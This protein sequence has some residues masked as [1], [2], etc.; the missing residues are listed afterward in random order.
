MAN[1]HHS[2]AGRDNERRANAGE[3]SQKSSNIF[4]EQA[5]SSDDI[6]ARRSHATERLR[7]RGI[8][9]GK[10]G[11][12]LTSHGS[13]QIIIGRFKVLGASVTPD[14]VVDGAVIE[15]ISQDGKLRRTHLPLEALHEPRRL[16]G[17]LAA[18][19]LD[20][21][22][23]I[24]QL[25]AIATVI[26]E[27]SRVR[28]CL[29]FNREGIHRAEL[30]GE[31]HYVAAI[32]GRFIAP[33]GVDARGIAPSNTIYHSHGTFEGWKR[34]LRPILVGN[35]LVVFGALIPLAAAVSP[36]VGVPS[37]S[38]VL[39]GS[40]SLGKSLTARLAQSFNYSP[41]RLMRWDGTENGIQA[42]AAAHCDTMLV[43]DELGTV[44][45]GRLGT[46]IYLLSGG[47]GKARATSSG[48]LRAAATIR[49]SVLATGEVSRAEHARSTREP[50]RDG[51][52]VRLITV[53]VKETYGVFS[54]LPRGVQTS[55]ELARRLLAVV[56]SHYGHAGPEFVRELIERQEAVIRHAPE[57]LA[58]Y[59]QEIV[60]QLECRDLSTIETRVLEGFSLLA[61]AG[62]LA[63]HLDILP[64]AGAGVMDAVRHVFGLW[65]TNWREGSENGH[66]RSVTKVR[67][68]FQQHAVSEFIP[69]GE[70]E[71]AS[72]RSRVGY[73]FGHRREGPLYL[74]HIDAMRDVVCAD[75]SLD[76]TLGALH[77]A[78]LL[79]T[80]SK[81]RQWLQRM[82]G[83]PKES[84]KSRMKF[85][86]IRGAILFDD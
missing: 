83:V 70:W 5:S 44:Q 42:Y 34:G 30:A 48:E 9:L 45:Q 68:W 59:R 65:L 49:C 25:R 66:N 78:G 73:R 62:K 80:P 17:H 79:A 61:L 81:G 15:A 75:L 7:E 11:L 36:L 19:G 74:V 77:A 46:M 32:G 22:I 43:L 3:T 76:E 82:P 1:E 39:I 6:A 33:S 56:S 10:H 57:K 37:P 35:P 58:Q 63:V 53:P 14:G 67:T 29:R 8:R 55:A 71:T 31:T 23:E 54:T 16:A 52:E 69:L 21:P 60:G 28:R 85:Y 4:R 24:Q 13:V 84:K 64:V 26:Y 38:A 50:L 18:I 41:E 12:E 72:R 40:S 86:A 51:Q 2:S 27:L 20:P 47:E